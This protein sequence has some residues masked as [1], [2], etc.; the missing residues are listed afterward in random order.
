MRFQAPQ[1][2][3]AFDFVVHADNVFTYTA[4]GGGD[5]RFP[6][7]FGAGNAGGDLE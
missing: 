5:G 1:P 3:D 4:A 2:G 7:F 6:V